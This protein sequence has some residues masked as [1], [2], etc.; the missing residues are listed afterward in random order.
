MGIFQRVCR[1]TE[2][3]SA[4]FHIN[5]YHRVPC[6]HL[7]FLKPWG[8][9]L[10]HCSDGHFCSSNIILAF[11]LPC[12]QSNCTSL[13]CRSLGWPRDLTWEMKSQQKWLVYFP[14][15]ILRSHRRVTINLIFLPRKSWVH[16]VVAPWDSV[17]Q[18]LQEHRGRAMLPSNPPPPSPDAQANLGG[19]V[20]ARKKKWIFFNPVRCRVYWLDSKIT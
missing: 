4:E 5:C 10:Y 6:S 14:N 7:E 11:H 1:P 9:Q 16:G 13:H 12:A 20:W 3:F 2:L 15:G 8:L 18:V 17:L 19:S